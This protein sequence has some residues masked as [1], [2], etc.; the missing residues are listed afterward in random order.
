MQDHPE[1]IDQPGLDA[2]EVA[3]EIQSQPHVLLQLAEN[4]L[5]V[6]DSLRDNYLR[7]T[8]IFVG[9]LRK[10]MRHAA[11]GRRETS[12]LTTYPADTLTWA[13]VRDEV[14]TFIDGGVGR[15]ALGGQQPILL[16][17]G[18]YAVRTGERD[19]AKRE[20]FG[21][22]PMILGDIE[23]GSK[24]RDD[25]VD[26][27]RITAELLAALSALERTPGLRVLMLHGPLVYQIWRYA[28]HAPFTEGDID[29]FLRHYAGNTELAA[30]LKEAFFREAERELYP[31]M[32]APPE[33]WAG[34]RLAEPLAW[35]GFLYRRLLTQARQR[36]PAPLVMG[37]VERGRSREFSESILLKRVFEGLRERGNSEFFNKLF[38]R[39]DLR[40]PSDLM[41]RLGYTDEM[42]LALVMKPGEYSE[43]WRSDKYGGLRML[44]IDFPGAEGQTLADFKLLRP[45]TR[46][47]YPTVEATYVHTSETTPPMRIEVLPA[48]GKHQIHEAARRAYLYARLLPGYGFPVGLDVV[49]RYAR[50]PEWLTDAYAKL[51]RRHLSAS[52]M[53]GEITDRQLRRMII[54]SIYMT[55]RDWLFRPQ[56]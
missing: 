13:D 18:S 22:Y 54:Q 52:L 29:L 5:T 49:D 17:V 27:V 23:G 10:A 26:I 44:Q 33:P 45:G 36:D 30:E 32:M 7:N 24:E 50:V 2:D 47:G 53:S 34:H 42:L 4:S 21:Y 28:G 16:R 55:G 46:H 3:R 11:E 40:Q 38:G 39:S 51:I 35:I 56:L 43:P 25:F 48:L 14:V 20:Q 41:D 19:L 6:A 9:Y 15:V 8:A 31:R 1:I 37:V 12:P